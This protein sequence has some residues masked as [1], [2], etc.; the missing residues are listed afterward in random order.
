MREGGYKIIDFKNK[1]IEE[2]TRWDVIRE[3]I[4][5]S[6]GK[7]ILISGLKYGGKVL[8]DFCT[9]V[10]VN[11]QNYIFLTII[12][13]STKCVDLVIMENEALYR[14][15]YLDQIDKKIADGDKATLTSA[16]QYAD[17]QDT[18]NLTTAKQYADT[19]DTK[20]LTTAKKYTDDQITAK[21]V[22]KADLNAFKTDVYEHSNIAYLP[23]LTSEEINTIKQATSGEYLTLRSDVF[24]NAVWNGRNRP[25]ILYV[26]LDDGGTGDFTGNPCYMWLTPVV[27]G[28]PCAIGYINNYLLNK[29]VVEFEGKFLGSNERFKFKFEVHITEINYNQITY[30][31][32]CTKTRIGE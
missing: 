9:T 6:D 2:V 23:S 3:D 30:S 7:S 16:K 1:A 13:T 21:A 20:N 31:L 17:T 15:Y 18:K 12:A 4:I 19:Q 24:S 29:Y 10:E 32:Y 14:Y 27:D 8:N 5:N 26:Q 28:H 22:T 25:D 11:A